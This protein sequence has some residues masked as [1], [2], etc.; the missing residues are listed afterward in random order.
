MN[1]DLG[2]LTYVGHCDNRAI[3]LHPV[4]GSMT[5]GYFSLIETIAYQLADG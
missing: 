3:T 2:K 5:V 4:I 1:R